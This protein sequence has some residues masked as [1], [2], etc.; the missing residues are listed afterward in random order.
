MV[1]AQALL[2][3][4]SPPNATDTSQRN[5]SNEE[6]DPNSQAVQDKILKLAGWLSF[7]REVG[8][9]DPIVIKNIIIQN[10]YSLSLEK[11]PTQNKSL[12]N[13][14]KGQNFIPRSRQRGK[15]GAQPNSSHEV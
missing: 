13:T 3:V 11:K 6:K 12:A 14:A 9:E 7:A 1:Q 2:H 15:L 8:T 10:G 5:M 4:K